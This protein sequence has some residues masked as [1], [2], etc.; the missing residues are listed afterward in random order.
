MPDTANETVRRNPSVGNGASTAIGWIG[1]LALAVVFYALLPYVK[2]YQP[3]AD[4]YFTAH[5]IEYAATGLFFVGMATLAVK[6]MR[7]PA[8]RAVLNAGLLDGFETRPKVAPVDTVQRLAAHLNLVARRSR[9]TFLVRRIEDLCEYVRGRRSVDGL[10]SQLGY[11][12]EV[13]SGRQHDG[14]AL[15]RTITWAI[16]ILGFLGTVIGITMSIANI[17]PDQLESSLG[18]VTAG[19]AVAFDTT[20]L[21]LALS[22]VLVFA[23]YL[24]ERQEQGILDAVE[25]F[26]MQKLLA[27]FPVDEAP[28]V[29]SPLM[30]AQHTAAAQ[31]LEKSEALIGWQ[32][33]AWQSSLETL[34][35][36]WA[37]TLAKQQETLDRALQ[38]GLT[39]ALTDHAAQ[40]AAVRTEFLTAFQQS[41][42]VVAEQ[43]TRSAATIEQSQQ[44][45]LER[46]QQMWH[47]L[48]GDW[49]AASQEQAALWSDLT[50]AVSTEVRGWQDQLQ[51]ATAAVSG[52]LDELRQQGT[53]LLRI[54][55]QEEQLVRLEDRLAQNLE[56][57]R[58]VESLEETMLNLNAAV[59][60]LSTKTRA[61][62]A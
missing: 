42:V 23:T 15:I 44:Q 19:L 57:V 7:L 11:L 28:A 55:E 40:L 27:L 56:A 3:D 29:D 52:Q 5:W 10:E 13:S 54:V 32:M 51:A 18:E 47:T 24:V 8:E 50:N 59:H 30:A 1:G 41:A 62:A 21:S 12:A 16:P 2:Q 61:K 31:L 53:V 14:Y 46:L 58:V 36:R 17:T 4:R 6:G 34:R 45:G 43:A 33:Q 35:E 9:G 49:T 60:L 39:T 22:M 26:A 20:A 37:G 25:D 48:R 38:S